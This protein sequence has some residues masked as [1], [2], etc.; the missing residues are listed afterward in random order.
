MGFHIAVADAVINTAQENGIKQIVLSGGVFA[1]EILTTMCYNRL[2]DLGFSVY[3][4]EQ[5]PPNDQGIALGQAW[6]AV[7]G[8]E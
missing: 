3:I 7:N 1:N 6:Y 2:S 8:Q 5:V 4:N